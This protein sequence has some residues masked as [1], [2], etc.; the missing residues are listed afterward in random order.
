V[1][2][3]TLFSW[4]DS[5][6]V[7]GDTGLQSKT[8]IL[9]TVRTS[10]LVTNAEFIAG[11][12]VVQVIFPIPFI[13]TNFTMM[14]GIEDLSAGEAPNYRTGDMHSKATTGYD[15]IVAILSNMVGNT[16]VIHSVAIHD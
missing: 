9:Q 12:A 4:K 14:Q 1:S 10:H 5:G 8:P 11:F 13:D 6:Q 15:A 16:F 7:G 2:A 3:F